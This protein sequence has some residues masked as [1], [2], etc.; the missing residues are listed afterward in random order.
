[1][2]F[3]DLEGQPESGSVLRP[4]GTIEAVCVE[5]WFND[6]V[7]QRDSLVALGWEGGLLLPTLCTLVCAGPAVG[8]ANMLLHVTDS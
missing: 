3:D 5:E 8:A 6:V 7:F 1:M 4:W 2:V